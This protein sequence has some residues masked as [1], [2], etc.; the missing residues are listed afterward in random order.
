MTEPH[1]DEV[2]T[3]FTSNR[4]T[5]KDNWTP[6]LCGILDWRLKEQLTENMFYLGGLEL[7]GQDNVKRKRPRRFVRS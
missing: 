3:A 6:D 5:L 7:G 1:S 2:L 4:N